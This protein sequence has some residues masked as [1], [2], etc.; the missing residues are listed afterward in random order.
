MAK[1]K[2]RAETSASG[3]ASNVNE[4]SVTTQKAFRTHAKRSCK[5][6]QQRKTRVS[7]MITNQR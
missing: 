6:C 2:A 4:E 7:V 5:T 3:S 1:S